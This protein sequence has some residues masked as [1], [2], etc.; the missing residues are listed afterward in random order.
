M[1]YNCKY[2][3]NMKYSLLQELTVTDDTVL[4]EHSEDPALV[5]MR[6]LGDGGKVSIKARVVPTYI[7]NCNCNTMYEHVYVDLLL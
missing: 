4:E 2:Q 5:Q 7:F 6:L 3:F 1:G